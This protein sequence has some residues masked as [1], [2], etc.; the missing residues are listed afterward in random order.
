MSARICLLLWLALFAVP[1]QAA[2]TVLA[3]YRLGESDP[4]AAPGVTGAM[5]T[6][7]TVQG[8]HLNRVGTPRYASEGRPQPGSTLSMSFNGTTDRYLGPVLSTLTTDFGIEAWVKSNGSSAGNATL[9]YNG[10]T[11]ST[12][13]GLF[14]LGSSYGFLYGGVA[15]VAA[16]PIST[17]WTHLALVREGGTTRFFVNGVQ[18]TTSTAAPAAATGNFLLAGNPLVASE[19][20]DGLVDEV[21]VFRFQP[22]QFRVT[23]LNL[24]G[25]PPATPVP[26]T[27]PLA[28]FVLGALLVGLTVR[29]ALRG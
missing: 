23:D 12:G 19:F 2:I 18:A 16:A 26:A 24:V 28:L 5:Q 27:G 13:W 6:I 21:R 4:G 11:D 3:H 10:R 1:A 8:N 9:A 20:F 25:A 22:G 17:Q 14:R 29:R 15:A 7:D